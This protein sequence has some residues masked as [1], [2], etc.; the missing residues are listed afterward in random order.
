MDEKSERFYAK[1]EKYGGW[2]QVPAGV[3]HAIFEEIVKP[4]GIGFV[5]A[6]RGYLARKINDEI[7]HVIKLDALK[8]AA[9]GVSYG[10]SLSYVPYPY[11]PKV[12]W[13]RTLKSVSLDL[14]EQPQN[15][16]QEARDPHGDEHLYIATSMLGEVCFREEFGRA[17]QDAAARIEKWFA[18]TVTLENI[19]SRCNEQ[20]LREEGGVRR[21]PEAELV[22]ALTL[23]RL[24]C[25]EEAS[26]ELRRFLSQSAAGQEAQINLFA[27][28]EQ[29][30]PR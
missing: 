9:Y 21:L 3:V 11:V 26:A 29:I 17:W 23:G 27:A 15:W 30:T 16:E 6:R 25:A 8:G 14:C 7:S 13:H 24:G 22:H 1:V 28:L 4:A 20:K 2:N 19:L 18:R 10:V 5:N 12:R